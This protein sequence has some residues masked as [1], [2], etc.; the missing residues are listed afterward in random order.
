MFVFM[1]FMPLSPF[2]LL[3]GWATE[4]DEGQGSVETKA[5]GTVQQL[6]EN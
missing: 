1:P 6:A 5:T 4:A 3:Q 2:V